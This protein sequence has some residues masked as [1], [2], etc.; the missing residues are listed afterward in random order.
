MLRV[1][2]PLP[3]DLPRPEQHV[4]ADAERVERAAGAHDAGGGAVAERDGGVAGHPSGRGPVRAGQDSVYHQVG[5]LHFQITLIILYF[6]L[7]LQFCNT[8]SLNAL[9]KSC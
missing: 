2:V 1:S 7:I 6:F 8:S 5:P 4:F 9:I 3:D